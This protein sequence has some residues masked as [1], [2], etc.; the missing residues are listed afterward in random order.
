MKNSFPPWL[1]PLMRWSVTWWMSGHRFPVLKAVHCFVKAWFFFPATFFSLLWRNC[2][3]SMFSGS[4]RSHH[5]L[6][7]HLP[8]SAS[9]WTKQP[10]YTCAYTHTLYLNI[11]LYM[12]H[13]TTNVGWAS[14]TYPVLNGYLSHVYITYMSWYINTVCMGCNTE[15]AH[16]REFWFVCIYNPGCVFIII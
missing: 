2:P 9:Q 1:H 11:Y 14:L 13:K 10:H 6:E 15:K 8:T 4:T 3:K 16:K 5:S 7:A 12:K